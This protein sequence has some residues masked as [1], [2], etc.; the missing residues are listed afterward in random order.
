MPQKNSFEELP[1]GVLRQYSVIVSTCNFASKLYSQK[2]R[3]DWFNWIFVDEAGQADEPNLLCCFGG[4]VNRKTRVVLFGDPYQLGPVVLS[5]FSN[6]H[7]LELSLLERLLSRPLYEGANLTE[8]QNP[9]CAKLIRNYRSHRA[10]IEYPNEAFYNGEL[11]AAASRE[12][13][14]SLTHLSFLPNKASFPLLFYGV[15]GKD[16]REGSSPSWFNSSEI[17]VVMNLLEELD[18]G[19]QVSID[20]IGLISPYRQQARKLEDAVERRGWK[21]IKIGSVE[22]FQG[23]E[24]RVV[25]LSTVRSSELHFDHDAHFKLGFLSN[26]KRV[27]VGITRAKS[28]LVI[29][30]NPYILR[31]DSFWGSFLDYCVRNNAYD[32]V[33]LR[34]LNEV[35]LRSRIQNL[36]IPC[37]NPAPLSSANDPLDSQS[38]G[39]S[40]SVSL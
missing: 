31:G 21:G 25:I 28:L 18:I 17:S 34:K 4:L 32:G 39:E 38:D 37:Q 13:T 27:N 7:G 20:D 29:V 26:A 19:E 10:I 9:L 1:V 5:Q 22:Q 11:I 3:K 33:P 36:G 40:E 35:R 30:G 16:E 15:C 2:I 14:D 24:K 23:Q 12:E 6:S 8:T